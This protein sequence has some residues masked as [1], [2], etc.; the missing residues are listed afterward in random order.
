LEEEEPVTEAKRMWHEKVTRRY[1]WWQM[2]V[3]VGKEEGDGPGWREW[4]TIVRE[5]VGNRCQRE[6][7][8][9][10]GGGN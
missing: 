5:R 8:V 3:G 2:R 9:V 7:K 1:R 4:N 10:S 6:M